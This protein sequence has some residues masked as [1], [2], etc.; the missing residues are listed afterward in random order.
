MTRTTVAVAADYADGPENGSVTLQQIVD[1]T[2]TR[3]MGRGGMGNSGGGMGRI[4][5]PRRATLRPKGRDFCWM[6]GCGQK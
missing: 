1:T 6:Q 2:A 4:E 3:P 5:D